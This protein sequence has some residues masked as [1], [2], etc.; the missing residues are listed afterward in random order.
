MHLS[1]ELLI[2]RVHKLLK[3]PVLTA[4]YS[5]DVM[6]MTPF[7]CCKINDAVLFFDYINTRRTRLTMEREVEKKL[8]FFDIMLDSGH[9]FLITTVFWKKTFTGL[10][11]DY[12]SFV[13]LSYKLV[14]IRNGLH[15]NTW[16]IKEIKK[17]KKILRKIFHDSRFRRLAFSS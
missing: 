6:L 4:L 9:S 11:T 10:V 3:G 7:V 1:V 14:L 2:F 12:F 16:P 17:L 5:V 13:L 8:P 15:R